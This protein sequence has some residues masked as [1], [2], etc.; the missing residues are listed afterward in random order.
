[1]PHVKAAYEKFHLKGF[2]IVSV[3]F[4]SKREDWLKAIDQLGMTWNHLSDL[5]GWKCSVAPIYGIKSIPYTILIGPDGIII[6]GDY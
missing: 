2:D 5:K 4:D 3:S 6:G 1:M